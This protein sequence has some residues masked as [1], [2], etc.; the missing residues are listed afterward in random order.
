[1]NILTYI[2]IFIYFLIH[3]TDVSISNLVLI[4]K[5]T[6]RNSMD[7]L[8]NLPR[9]EEVVCQR[10]VNMCPGFSGGVAGVKKRSRKITVDLTPFQGVYVLIWHDMHPYYGRLS[11]C[12]NS[13]LPTRVLE[14]VWCS[15]HGWSTNI[16]TQTITLSFV[17]VNFTRKHELLVCSSMTWTFCCY[18][19][20][21]QTYWIYSR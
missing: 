12:K 11:S 20:H 19:H 1:M 14:R 18:S 10:Y 16:S 2:Y 6:P 21:V 7:L 5:W 4:P 17:Y 9:L 3:P 13:H 15:V 8:P